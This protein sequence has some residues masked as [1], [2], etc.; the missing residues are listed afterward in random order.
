LR[1]SS[2]LP[3]A[4][5]GSFAAGDHTG[6]TFDC[7][8]RID[9]IFD[10]VETA[11]TIPQHNAITTATDYAPYFGVMHSGIGYVVYGDA[12]NPTFMF[13]AAKDACFISSRYAHKLPHRDDSHQKSFEYLPRNAQRYDWVLTAQ[14]SV[15][16]HELLNKLLPLT[17]E[18]TYHVTKA[19]AQYISKRAFPSDI[20]FNVALMVLADNLHRSHVPLCL[21]LAQQKEYKHV[22]RKLPERPAFNRNWTD[23]VHHRN[24]PEYHTVNAVIADLRTTDAWAYH[25]DAP[26]SVHYR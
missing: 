12:N 8:Y 19:R 6:L 10:W 22:W 1:Y 26:D 11:H 15:A 18:T 7:P 4:S 21:T 14:R 2:E 23:I 5:A 17:P 13:T 24:A 25:S 3:T 20:T 16:Y 9:R